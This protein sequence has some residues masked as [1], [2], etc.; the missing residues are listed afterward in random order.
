MSLEKTTME[1]L[2]FIKYLYNL[3][4]EQ[5]QKPDPL[6]S[7]SLL[8]FHDS[9]DMFLFLTA[10]YLD[11]D[12]SKLDKNRN[13]VYF[14]DYWKIMPTSKKIPDIKLTQEL[15]MQRLNDARNQFK[16]KGIR[17]SVSDIES[18]RESAT[19]FFS[20]NTPLVF[21]I[22]FSDLSLID[23]IQFDNARNTLKEAQ[24]LLNE[25]KIEDALDKIAIAFDQLISGYE[26]NKIGFRGGSPFS[27]GE[28]FDYLNSRNIFRGYIESSFDQRN[29]EKFVDSVCESLSTIQQALKLL[30]FGIDYRKYTK[31][32]FYMPILKKTMQG[33]IIIQKQNWGSRGLP[34]IK[35]TQFCIDFIIESAIILQEFDCSNIEQ[36][37][38]RY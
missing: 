38:R 17:P 5:S 2:A 11:A 14:M 3:A 22:E 12:L 13:K 32:N 36:Y 33:R 8:T 34:N 25:N 15:S 10:E 27:F 30:S 1:R 16:H 19:N 4:F 31:F 18:F 26:N 9:I 29:L 37:T 35:D 24:K 28:S 6:C 7:A 21:D 23:L 20:E